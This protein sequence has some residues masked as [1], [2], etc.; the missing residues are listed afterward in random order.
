MSPTAAELAFPAFENEE[1]REPV[2]GA[3]AKEPS[4]RSGSRQSGTPMPEMSAKDL[5][6]E[7]LTVVSGNVD[8]LFTGSGPEG[9]RLDN[10][11][12]AKLK[13]YEMMN[14]EVKAEEFPEE[15]GRDFNELSEDQRRHIIGRVNQK[16]IALR[17]PTDA[18][19]EIRSQSPE[20]EDQA[21]PSE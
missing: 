18:E 13:Q 11:S 17:D 16:L 9:I 14:E 1:R 5:M 8:N 2:R 15:A 7:L 3:V 4:L 19:P 20:P 12:Y 10:D 21:G 6:T